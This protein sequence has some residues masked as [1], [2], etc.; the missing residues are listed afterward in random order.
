MAVYVSKDPSC[1]YD[2]LA[3]SFSGE[4]TVEVPL[5]VGN[6]ADLE[7]VAK[8]F[9]IAFR[10]FPVTKESKGGTAKIRVCRREGCGQEIDQ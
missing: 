9:G 3:R 8:R 10:P 6:H 7:P 4:W 1:L 5:V 2:I